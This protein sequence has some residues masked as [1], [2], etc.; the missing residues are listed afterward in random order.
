MC[1]FANEGHIA[2]AETAQGFKADGAESVNWKIVVPEVFVQA[3]LVLASG[4]PT[5]VLGGAMQIA[6]RE[7]AHERN[8]LKRDQA[9]AGCGSESLEDPGYDWWCRSPGACWGLLDWRNTLS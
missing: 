7:R 4:S 1:C 8:L 5:C 6:G 2:I 3:V 9:Q